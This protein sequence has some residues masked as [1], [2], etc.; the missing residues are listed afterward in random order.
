MKPREKGNGNGHG[1]VNRF[2]RTMRR[3]GRMLR[4]NGKVN[5]N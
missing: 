4:I 2:G 3:M 5:G 1:K